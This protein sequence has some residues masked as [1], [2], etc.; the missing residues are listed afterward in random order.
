MIKCT[1]HFF[2]WSAKW[3]GNLSKD[4]R[5]AEHKSEMHVHSHAEEFGHV[6]IIH[7]IVHAIAISLGQKWQRAHAGKKT[8]LAANEVR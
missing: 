1:G 5:A 4:V 7:S 2:L 8:I 6:S 3:K